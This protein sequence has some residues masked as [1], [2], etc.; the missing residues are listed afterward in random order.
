M[1]DIIRINDW[2]IKRQLDGSY[3][4]TKSTY[5]KSFKNLLKAIKWTLKQK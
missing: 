1:K 4:A 2:N 5:T 3:C